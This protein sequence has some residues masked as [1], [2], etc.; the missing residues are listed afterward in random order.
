VTGT[1]AAVPRAVVTIRTRA[2]GIYRGL[3]QA[4]GSTTLV[5]MALI[6]FFLVVEAT[7]ALRVAGLRFF[8]TFEWAPDAAVPRFGV[9]GTLYGTFVSALIAMVMAVPLGVG[10][11]L[12]IN[13]YAPRRIKRTLTSL[14][15]LL[16][17]IPSVI[18]GIWGLLFFQERLIGLSDWLS[19]YLG[20]IPV[21]ESKSHLF[22]GSY[23]VAG[24][25]LGFM[26]LPITT[27]VVREVFAQTPRGEVEAALALGGTRWGM[28]RTVVL[29]FGRGGIVGG[30][31]L[32]LGRALGET[33]AVTL[34]LSLS[35][36]VN[37]RILDAGGSSIASLIASQFGEANRF[38][39]QALMAAGLT[40]FVVTLLVN[41]VATFVVGRSRSGK[42]VDI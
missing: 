35:Y 5:L 16:A 21:F 32:A 20:F 34:I 25:V 12:F 37:P 41:M 14:V 38:G 11:A 10:T 18:F 23:F 1:R 8:T 19:R 28:I 29:P 40:L 22:G 2:D 42:G 4:A 39:R 36:G 6:A 27:S 15:D 9:A 3:A 26:V 33:I 30:S 17:A 31:M 13:E 24:L 7:P